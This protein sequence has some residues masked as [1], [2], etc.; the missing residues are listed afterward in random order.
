[1]WRCLTG[2]QCALRMSQLD[3]CCDLK[4]AIEKTY[5]KENLQIRDK[6]KKKVKGAQEAH[7]CIRPTKMKEIIPGLEN[8]EQRFI[9]SCQLIKVNR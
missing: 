7:E 5:G 9:V 1:M 6:T 2:R 4:E 8:D 3:H